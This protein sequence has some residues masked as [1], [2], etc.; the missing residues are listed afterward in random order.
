[1]AFWLR[2]APKTF[3]GG[4]FAPDPAGE[5]TTLLRPP[6]RMGRGHHIP[7]PSPRRLQ[8]LDLGAEGAW[9]MAYHFL[10]SAAAG[11]KLPQWV[12][13]PNPRRQIVFMHFSSQDAV[14]WNYKLAMAGTSPTN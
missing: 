4:Y 3:F 11:C 8:R 1:M 14:Y 9:V 6:S 10:T 2:N 13:G 7:I 12:T 5:L